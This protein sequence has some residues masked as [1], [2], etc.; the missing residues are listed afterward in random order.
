[1]II[2]TLKNRTYKSLISCMLQGGKSI[3][4]G[5]REISFHHIY[6]RGLKLVGF[7][8]ISEMWFPFFVFKGFIFI[9]SNL[10]TQHGV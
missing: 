1:M 5:D 7:F 6:L 10:C 3:G 2:V 8:N 9:L 4:L